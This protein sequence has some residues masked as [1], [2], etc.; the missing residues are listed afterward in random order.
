MGIIYSAVKLSKPEAWEL[1]KNYYRFQDL[2]PACKFDANEGFP[3]Y[4][5]EQADGSPIGQLLVSLASSMPARWE[6]GRP[7]PFILTELY[8][9][10]DEF[11]KKIE[12]LKGDPINSFELPH[13]R[14]F[15]RWAGDDCIA[16]I[17]DID[18]WAYD[19]Q[20]DP[21]DEQWCGPLK[22]YRM[23]DDWNGKAGRRVSERLEESS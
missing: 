12:E 7:T 23:M 22:N 1:G 10:I 2:F 3:G 8:P 5:A 15:Y 14:G 11:L 6:P 9:T 19:S 21:A 16:I 13:W 18:E 17:G 20:P 4:I